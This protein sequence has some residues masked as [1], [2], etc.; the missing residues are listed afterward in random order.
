MDLLDD[1]K[2]HLQSIVNNMQKEIEKSKD[3]G[4]IVA[5]E[6]CLFSFLRLPIKE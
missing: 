5:T 4:S 2:S 1:E 3:L 6:V